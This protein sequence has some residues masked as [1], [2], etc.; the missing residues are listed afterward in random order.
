MAIPFWLTCVSC[1]CTY[2]AII[3]ALIVVPEMLQTQYGY[4]LDDAG[5]LYAVPYIVSAVI[6]LPLGIFVDKF[7]HRMTVTITGS[8]LMLSAHIYQLVLPECD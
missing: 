5:K 2:I 3:N 1:F 6:S 7:G 8:V 4:T